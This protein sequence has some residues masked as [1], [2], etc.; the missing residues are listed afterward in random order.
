MQCRA[1]AHLA[2]LRTPSSFFI[3][4]PAAKTTGQL[5][6]LKPADHRLVAV[7][8]SLKVWDGLSGTNGFTLVSVVSSEADSGLGGGDSPN[9]T[10][11][12]AAGRPG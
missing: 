1:L 7:Q 10:N 6:L 3:N 5:A 8:V 2:H 4:V 11:P 12:V 9:D